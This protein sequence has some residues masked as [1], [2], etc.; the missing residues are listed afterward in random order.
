MSHDD[1]VYTQAAKALQNANYLL[2]LAGAGF[3][4]DSGLSTYEC[5]PG[6]YKEWCDPSMLAKQPQQ[7]HQFWKSFSNTYH[8]TK[9]HTGYEIL[10]QWCHGRKLKHLVDKSSA[11]W[12]YT[13]NVDGHFRRFQNFQNSLCEIHG[14][15]GEFRCASATG[16]DQQ[17]PRIGDFWD[18]WNQQVSKKT[19]TSE[20]QDHLIPVPGQTTTLDDK[21]T[22]TCPYCGGLARPNVLMFH[23]TDANVLR[24]IQQQRDRYQHWEA[25][26]EDSV[27]NDGQNLLILELGCGPNVPAVRHESEEVLKDCLDR[28]LNTGKGTA[29]LIRVNPKDAGIDNLNLQNDVI[30]IYDTALDA[31]LSIDQCLEDHKS[32]Q[33]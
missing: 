30:S 27:E 4:A 6:S 5:M 23:D 9:P 10:D 8:D 22:N 1:S 14:Y 18:Q 33:L 26:M 16:Y 32:Q 13:S 2:I 31:L 24:S 7:F 21:M 25:Q 20:C 12:V 28:I 17:G 19:I 11:W 15:A 29:T 3:S